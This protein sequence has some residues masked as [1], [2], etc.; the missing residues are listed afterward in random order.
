MNLF[1]EPYCLLPTASRE[2]VWVHESY[3]DR[4]AAHGFRALKDFL[5][6]EQ[7]SDKTERP[8][9]SLYRLSLPG[10]DGVETVYLKI[11]RR[12]G[13]RKAWEE[14]AD[15]R[16]PR[17][18]GL[19]EMENLLWFRSVGVDT[20]FPIAAGERKVLGIETVSFLLTRSVEPYV[21]LWD[22]LDEL[23]GGRSEGNLFREKCRLSRAVA[24]TLSRLHQAGIVYPG[25]L[26]KHVYVEP[27]VEGDRLPGI[28]LLDLKKPLREGRPLSRGPLRDLANFMT[29]LGPRFV[30]NADRFRFVCHYKEYG[31]PAGGETFRSLVEAILGLA[32]RLRGRDVSR[33]RN[34]FAGK[35]VDP[36]RSDSR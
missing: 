24:S 30:T 2:R 29:S 14:M 33:F 25:F 28:C 16:K 3:Q 36:P 23:G 26:A 20:A 35:F 4:L 17:S 34:F 9:R 12:I 6:P 21:C 19:A 15:F 32:E 13:F 5:D 1:D 8:G 27:D 10:S 7:I 11:H 22:R 31:G 18:K